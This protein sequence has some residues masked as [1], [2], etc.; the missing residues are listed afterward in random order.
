M[1]IRAEEA[2]L[3]TRSRG[4]KWA[5]VKLTPP[6]KRARHLAGNLLDIMRRSDGASCI[7]ALP[8]RVLVER[9]SGWPEAP[10]SSARRVMLSDTLQEIRYQNA[11]FHIVATAETLVAQRS[12]RR[13]LVEARQARVLDRHAAAHHGANEKQ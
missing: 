7:A 3:S 2:S 12:M 10:F 1:A 6:S 11:N 8:K 13:S 5:L 9:T 4:E